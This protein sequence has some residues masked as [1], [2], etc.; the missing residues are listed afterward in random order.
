MSL[1]GSAAAASESVQAT[2]P[3]EPPT[4]TVSPKIE[5]VRF[6]CCKEAPPASAARASGAERERGRHRL[7]LHPRKTQG[8]KR[9][10]GGGGGH[11]GRHTPDF[12]MGDLF[13]RPGI[14][15]AWDF[16]NCSK[17]DQ[18]TGPLHFWKSGRVGS[19]FQPTNS[20]IVV[21]PGELPL[22]VGR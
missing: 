3:A 18:S 10:G 2:A 6:L 16:Q 11:R 8:A 19:I 15:R 9:R 5:Q 1:Q 13:A 20:A 14:F 22:K 17:I 12:G 21:S 4:K 7:P